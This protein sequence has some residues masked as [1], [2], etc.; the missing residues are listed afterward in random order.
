MHYEPNFLERKWVE[1][2]D[3]T[4]RPAVRLAI[5]LFLWHEFVFV[6]R[7]IP[8]MIAD[9]IPYFRQFKIQDVKPI[10]NAQ[11]WKCAT[12]V[13]F[14]Q[15]FLQLPMMM[16]FHPLA[17]A[18]G[19]RFLETPFPT[20]SH[21]ITTSLFFLFMEDF[22]QYFA[23]RLLHWGI[24]YKNIH[25]LHHEFSA[26]FGIASEYAHPM[27]TLILGLG[28]FLGPLVWVL[29]FHDLHVISLAVWLAVRLIQVVDSHSG[30]DFPWSLRHIFPF[31]AGADF[32]DYHHMAFVGNYSSSFRWWDWAFG[33]DNAYQQWKLKKATKKSQ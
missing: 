29:T 8:Y 12:H 24:L 28:F 32:H 2:F 31:W 19:M 25:K 13:M 16:A 9:R 21:L 22:Y 15:T 30:Y 6:T 20:I 18:L 26:P 1:I 11:W 5:V 3:G 23:H 4:E 7:Y 14:H 27:E 33:T 17:M 10:T